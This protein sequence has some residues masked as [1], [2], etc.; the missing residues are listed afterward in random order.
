MRLD[1]G[2]GQN[3]RPA[4]RVTPTPRSEAQVALDEARLSEDERR[5][6]R[7]IDL[8]WILGS[9]ASLITS[10][11]D[12]GRETEVQD[13]SAGI[14]ADAGMQVDRWWIDLEELR[15]HPAFSCEV[16]RAEA[17]GVVGVIGGSTD[18]TRREPELVVRD[19]ILNG[20]VDVV[21]PGD[22]THWTSSPWEATERGGAIYGRGAVDM[23]GGIACALG[24]VRALRD[25][26]VR[27]SGRL[28]L[29]SVVGEEDGGLGTLAAITRGYRADGAIVMEPTQLSIVLAQAGCLDFRLMVRGKAGH[30]AMRWEGVSAIDKFVS[31]YRALMA[32]E[33]RRTAE[34][35]PAGVGMLFGEYPVPFPISIGTVRA[36][37]WASTVPEVL[38]CEGRYGV[39][40]GEA[41]ESA[42]ES[43][44]Q[45]LSSAAREDEWLRDHVPTVEWFGARY[46]SA[47]I[48]R[49][50]CLTAVVAAAHADVLSEPPQ[51]R[52]VTYGAD[53]G[54]LV[55][56]GGMD[57]LLYGPG[58]VRCAHRPDEH[59][60]TAALLK[61]TRALVVAA[62]RFC[63]YDYH[64]DETSG[65]SASA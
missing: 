43:F 6:V 30:G 3:P 4:G 50:S 42:R 57:A 61:A 32:L 37:D 55:S 15:G 48:S 10:R 53:M 19:L 60:E 8:D 59:I 2:A 9:L 63:G 21:P 1:S 36:G 5:A 62:M 27:L 52:A 14:M 47:S 16:S 46:A 22:L 49:D 29:E 25:A 7:A 26:G 23:K 34:S 33:R 58:D 13:R 17:L 28:I 31:V 39:M 24:A 41:P 51:F 40:P 44:E 12:G 35:L 45:A 11:S 20:H 18:R 56:V 65:R 64:N 54:M 38:V